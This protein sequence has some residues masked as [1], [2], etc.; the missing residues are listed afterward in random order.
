M[1]I[2]FESKSRRETRRSDVNVLFFFFLWVP[3]CSPLSLPVVAGRNLA[4]KGTCVP[5]LPLRQ[6]PRSLRLLAVVLILPW[7]AKP[8]FAIDMTLERVPDALVFVLALTAPF[9]SLLPLV[10]EEDQLVG[11]LRCG[12]DLWP[13]EDGQEEENGRDQAQPESRV[14][15][16]DVV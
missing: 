14:G 6:R 12:E 10:S 9:F 16:E 3:S 8:V 2:A 15:R 4:A 13:Q 11:P 5:V 7:Q 1:S